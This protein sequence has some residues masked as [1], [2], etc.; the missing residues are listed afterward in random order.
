MSRH[1]ASKATASRLTLGSWGPSSCVHFEPR[2]LEVQLGTAGGLGAASGY[3]RWI[4]C[5]LVQQPLLPSRGPTHTMLVVVEFLGLPVLERCSRP[6]LSGDGYRHLCLTSGRSTSTASAV[7]K[8]LHKARACNRHIQN[9]RS[10][11]GLL[12]FSGKCGSPGKP[13]EPTSPHRPALEQARP[14]ECAGDHHA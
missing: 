7:V 8:R 12:A 4:T 2:L 6:L 10:V 5:R 1:A 13:Y 9:W 14:S 3:R 11:E